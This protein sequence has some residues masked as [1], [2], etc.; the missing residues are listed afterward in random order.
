MTII[1]SEFGNTQI[2]STLTGRNNVPLYART[3]GMRVRVL[4]NGVTYELLGGT[5]DGYW[6]QIDAVDY[7]LQD[8]FSYTIYVATSGNDETGTGTA[9]NPYRQ[10]QRALDSIPKDTNGQYVIQCSAGSF[11]MPRIT[12]L[13]TGTRIII[14]GS[15]DNL[16][17]SGAFTYNQVA[18]KQTYWE[19]NI[20]AYGDTITDGSHYILFPQDYGAYGL[21]WTAFNSFAS[22]T[23]NF[24]IMAGFN[25]TGTYGTGYIYPIETTFVIDEYLID[26]ATGTQNSRSNLEFVGIEFDC[27]F[28]FA[29][30]GAKYFEACVFTSTVVNS[31]TVVL[32]NCV[33]NSYFDSNISQCSMN[34]GGTLRSIHE[35]HLYLSD[36][37]YNVTSVNRNTDLLDS[38]IIL[39]NSSKGGDATYM[40]INGIDF[41]GTSA[42]IEVAGGTII[43]QLDVTISNSPTRFLY[44]LETG[45][46]FLRRGGTIT[47]STTYTPVNLVN[48]G[49]AINI[50]VAANGTLTNSTTPGAEIQVGNSA[51][52]DSFSDL[53]I[54]D[55]TTMC[56]AT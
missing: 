2:V 7:S 55:A 50:K 28:G 29:N 21:F 35:G 14:A 41:E 15:R 45:G 6:T 25:I 37:V 11:E 10:P 34:R 46:R 5:T 9:G 52:V 53:P 54:I 39:S 4:E 1:S 44:N 47:G 17:A 32:E 48:G 13:N 51:P 8:Q 26:P 23:P 20:G 22:T 27:Q 49:Q 30:F 19:A 33:N 43:Q 18:G 40:F 3:E 31:T 38:Q 42:C 12:S 36:G 16:V 24:R 56:R